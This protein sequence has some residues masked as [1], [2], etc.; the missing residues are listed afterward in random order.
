MPSARISDWTKLS[1]SRSSV[2]FRVYMHPSGAGTADGKEET[3]VEV[4]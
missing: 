1:G 4:L 3:V 2:E